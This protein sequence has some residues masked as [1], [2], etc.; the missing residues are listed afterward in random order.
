MKKIYKIVRYE[1]VP[2]IF[3]YEVSTNEGRVISYACTRWGARRIAR[4]DAHNGYV[5]VKLYE[6]DVNENNV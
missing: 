4:R 1:H 2:I 5:D 3:R 6:V